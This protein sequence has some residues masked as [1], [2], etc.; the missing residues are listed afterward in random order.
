M[1]AENFVRADGSAE[2]LRGVPCEYETYSCRIGGTFCIWLPNGFKEREEQWLEVKHSLALFARDLA[3]VLRPC[4][5]VCTP[6][7][8]AA[9]PLWRAFNPN[10][11]HVPSDH[12]DR[13]GVD[14]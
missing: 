6:A 1:G 13:L 9:S 8:A 4:T 14:N 3:T 12:P 10:C 5:A 2:S 11:C 7:S